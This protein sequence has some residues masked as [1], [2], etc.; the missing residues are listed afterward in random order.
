MSSL[1]FPPRAARRRGSRNR[2]LPALFE[3]HGVDVLLGVALTGFAVALL[4]FLPSSFNVDSWLALVTGRELWHS[5]LPHHEV[6]TSMSF[7]KTW[8]DQQWGAQ[9][10]T[11]GLFL[12]G[13]L[14]LVGVVNVVL[15]VVAVAGGVI[16]ARRLGAS[17]RSVLAALP[18][19]LALV[20]DSHEVRTQEFAMPLFIACVYLLARD[21]RT[22]SRRVYWCLPILVL[23]A[24]LHGS[25]TL[26]AGLVA[27]RGLTVAWERRSSLRSTARAWVRPLVL[28]VGAPL[29]LLATP[30]GAGILSYY[31]T[32]LLGN[33]VM[34]AVSE[35]QPITSST[36][37]AVPFFIAAALALWCVG[38]NSTRTTAFERLALLA[39]GVISIEV[40]RNAL[41]FGLFALLVLPLLLGLSER[42]GAEADTARRR[43]GVINLALS[44]VAAL[45]LIVGV[46]AAFARP[47]S[48]TEYHYIQPGVLQTVERATSANPSLRTLSDV[49]FSDWL[50][51]RDPALAGRIA[52]DTSWELLTPAQMNSLQAVFGVVGTNWKR[53]ADGYRLLVLDQHA[54]PAAAAA[55][56]AEPGARV[57]Y[58]DGQSIV[59]LRSA[60]EA[61]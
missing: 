32:M 7:G 1:A 15:I 8:I 31:R 61:G 55:F 59:I 21:S 9:L 20:G 2:A 10:A 56:R 54:E 16:G 3:T 30:Y 17:P 27:L 44:G 4:G 42:H 11:Y 12:A 34:K 50:L 47:A 51:W 26:G 23:W 36:M 29:C 5:G 60:S 49:R 48:S 38:R 13:G 40:V 57:L 22:P 14:N 33:S 43:R 19:C 6:L 58:D 41:F 25:A 35:W 52:Y 24:N 53:A 39:L 37:V 28:T 45:A 46:S 18:L